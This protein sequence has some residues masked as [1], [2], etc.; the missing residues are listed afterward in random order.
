MD[1]PQV[2]ADLILK[3]ALKT[4]G[5]KNRDDMTVLVARFERERELE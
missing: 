2:I 4:A 3:Y 5:F 1:E